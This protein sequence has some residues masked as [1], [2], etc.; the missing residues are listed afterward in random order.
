MLVYNLGPMSVQEK[1]KLALKFQH[2]GDLEKARLIYLEV[3]DTE[4]RNVDALH[5]YGLAC[6]Q[7]G[8]HASAVAYIGKAVQRVPEQPVLR[9]NYGD[10]L[11]RA[12][13]LQGAAVQLHKALE[14]RPDY[15]GAHLNL[16]SVYFD[17]GNHAAALHHA[18][19]AVRL[20]PERADA[21]FNLGLVLLDHV[22]LNE[23]AEA[24][25]QALA[26]RPRYPVAA[27]A[28]LYT[29]NL[30]PSADPVAVAD[31]HRNVAAKLFLP[32]QP[33]SPDSEKKSKVP[34]RIGYVSGD[35]RAHAVNYFFTPL[36]EHRD[37]GRFE[38]FCYSN[39]DEPDEVTLSIAS[40]SDHWREVAGLSDEALL[41]QIRA[42]R[43]DVL[44]DLAGYTK[45]SRLAVFASRAA[46]LQISFLGYPN[47]TG[48]EAMDY[49]IVDEITAPRNEHFTGTESP[50]RL[51]GGFACF[52]PP[53]H[54]PPVSPPPVLSRKSATFGS[55]HKL[56][57]INLNV[58]D[59]WAELLRQ[60][61]GSRLLLAR[62][63]LDD[64]QQERLAGQFADRGIGPERLVMKGFNKADGSFLELFAEIDIQLDSFPWSGHTMAC[65]ALWMGVPVVSLY[66]SSHAGR[67]VASVLHT[68]GLGELLAQDRKSYLKICSELCRAPD[69]LAELRSGLRER[70]ESSLLRDEVAYTKAFEKA[71]MDALTRN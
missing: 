31:E 25:R 19:E 35:F 45:Y 57:K 49:R 34:V 39:A 28:Y 43:I 30:L 67:M 15:P 9:N 44:F 36:L 66:G 52:R 40:H 55:F 59:C 61:P 42:D 48:L 21:R 53:P 10:A 17:S 68:I 69:R 14:L 50:L 60:N 58:V 3:L 24:F 12:G 16:G 63:E 23:A 27:G 54:A 71:V 6:H 7:Q 11:R 62:D 5:L 70:M 41:S 2:N 32:E 1:I 18:R 38:L 64:W 33:A 56:E 4:P 8:D 37:T 46:P 22:A 51:S 26:I 47:T 20:A 65:M 29:L 13:D